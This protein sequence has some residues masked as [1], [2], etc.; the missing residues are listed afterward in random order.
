MNNPTL[1]PVHQRS[2]NNILRYQLENNQVP[3]SSIQNKHSDLISEILSNKP[4][5]FIT[6]NLNPTNV[7]RS[8]E[9][10][11]RP[12]G[13]LFIDG[14]D[15]GL[16]LHEAYENTLDPFI[17]RLERDLLGSRAKVYL[18]RLAN[19]RSYENSGR[20]YIAGAE[21]NHVH[22]LFPL[23][24]GRSYARFCSLFARLFDQLVYPVPV[25]TTA[26]QGRKT[27]AINTIEDLKQG[28]HHGSVLDFKPGRYEEP[29]SHISYSLKQI[30]NN[31]DI[32]KFR[33][34]YT[35]NNNT[36]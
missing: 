20:K 11:M 35:R 12:L 10:T 17:K 16:L 7:R 30:P 31:D 24:S 34:K 29:N 25:Y 9:K 13:Q 23:P 33:I 15:A 8:L 32:A 18:E 21:L 1:T 28:T 19:V 36:H 27:T 4:F 5:V 6:I 22:I 26:Q 2:L 3:N 14:I